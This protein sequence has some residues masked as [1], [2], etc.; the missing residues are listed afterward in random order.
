MAPKSEAAKAAKA[1]YHKKYFKE[2]YQRNKTRT[3]ERIAKNKREHIAKVRAE[4][5]KLKD[6][7]CADCCQKFHPVAMDFDHVRGEKVESIG[8]FIGG[9]YR[10]D[11][12][13]E[14]IKKCEVV[15]ACCHRIRTHNRLSGA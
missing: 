4:I 1:A 11:L 10:I 2:W 14:E 15:C 13:L 9:G 3:L 7:P 5:N 12:V 6:V 8:K